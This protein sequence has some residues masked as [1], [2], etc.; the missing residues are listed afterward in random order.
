MVGRFVEEQDVR[1]GER[2]LR[3]GDSALL[4]PCTEQRGDKVAPQFPESAINKILIKSEKISR[5]SAAEPAPLQHRQTS[6]QPPDQGNPY[7][8]VLNANSSIRSTRR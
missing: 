8:F 7:A 6:T 1:P 2:N 3:K 4:A 5:A